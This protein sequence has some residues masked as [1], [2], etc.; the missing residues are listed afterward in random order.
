MR[1]STARRSLA[2]CTKP[3]QI[4]QNTHGKSLTNQNARG[5]K[6]TGYYT[7][8]PTARERTMQERYP[9][10][11]TNGQATEEI[12]EESSH[13]VPEGGDATGEIVNDIVSSNILHC[14][15]VLR[16]EAVS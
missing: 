4:W 7:H 13:Q 15:C 9:Q 12:D 8:S 5:N 11:G 10:Y 16:S 14:S 6:L 3:S 2:R 1:P